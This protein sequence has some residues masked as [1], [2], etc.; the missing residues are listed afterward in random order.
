L[1]ICDVFDDD[2]EVESGKLKENI[3]LI[4]DDDLDDDDRNGAG[5]G[6]KFLVVAKIV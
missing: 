2:D 5:V 4:D 1:L 3:E 6:D